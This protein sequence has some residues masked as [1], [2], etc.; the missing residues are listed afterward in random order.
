MRFCKGQD[1]SLG[2]QQGGHPLLWAWTRDSR[3]KRSTNRFM[4]RNYN[5]RDLTDEEISALIAYKDGKL[6]RMAECEKSK[7]DTER[8]RIARFDRFEY[9]SLSV[10]PLY[11]KESYEGIE[12]LYSAERKKLHAL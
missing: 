3:Y 7:K 12:T 5:C 10:A 2:G 9:R 4:I 6:D 11:R 8:V 1:H